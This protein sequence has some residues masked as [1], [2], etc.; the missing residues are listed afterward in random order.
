MPGQKDRWKDER[1]HRPY[2]IGPFWLPPGVQKGKTFF[3]KIDCE[4]TTSYFPSL[5]PL[6]WYFFEKHNASFFL[7]D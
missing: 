5:V 1:M 3:L 2:F 7:L 6:C 4:E